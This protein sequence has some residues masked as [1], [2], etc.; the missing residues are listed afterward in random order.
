MLNIHF[1]SAFTQDWEERPGL[2]N[3]QYIQENKSLQND[4]ILQEKKGKKMYP[5]FTLKEEKIE[6]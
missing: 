2:S 5:D 3:S 4:K 6:I 1:N